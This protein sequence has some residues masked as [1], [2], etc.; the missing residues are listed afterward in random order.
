[1]YGAHGDFVQALQTQHRALTE[2][3][4]SRT[5]ID[6]ILTDFD[7]D[8]REAIVSLPR[9]M[10]VKYTAENDCQHQ[11]STNIFNIKKYMEENSV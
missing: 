2:E 11:K 9:K 8:K 5:E 1:M 10:L 3:S 6:L 4:S 7:T